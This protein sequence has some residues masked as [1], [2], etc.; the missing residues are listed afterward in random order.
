MELKIQKSELGKLL[1]IPQAI[2]EKRSTMPILANLLLTAGEDQLRITGS[3]LEVTAV[4][5]GSASVK[6]S[7]S[8][9]VNGK[10]FSELVRELPEAEISIKL[11]EGNRVE[12]KA[13]SSHLKLVGIS[14]D[15]YPVPPGIGIAVKNRLSAKILAEMISKTVYAVSMDEGRYTMSGVC[16]E[17]VKEKKSAALRLVATDGHRLAMITRTIEGLSLNNL[18]NKDSGSD[19]VIVPRKGLAEIRRALEADLD[20]EVG[21]DFSDGFMVLEAGST[22]LA[23]R[24]V[25]GEFPEYEGVFPSSAGSLCTVLSSDLA[26]AL[27]RVSLMVSDKNKGVRFDV[28]KNI[29]RM[30]SSSPELGEAK[31]EV[32]VQYDGA[33]M[34]IGFNARY[35]LEMLQSFGETQPVILEL[36]GETGPGKFYT[37][38]DSSYISIIMPLRLDQA[39]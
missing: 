31:E 4:S 34:S 18:S 38:A 3:D 11:V 16:F 9:T 23:V 12:V 13:G 8:I 6:K 36:F 15:E 7:G 14:A 25:D 26:H 37:E 1:H 33:P 21:V 20:R 17:L 32:S 35:I 30:S 28:D 2:A 10:M 22:K 29:I 19:H 5:S 24:L 27:R 39:S